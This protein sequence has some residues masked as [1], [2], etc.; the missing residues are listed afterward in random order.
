MCSTRELKERKSEREKPML[1]GNEKKSR[2]T[3]R[4]RNFPRWFHASKL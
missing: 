1:K 3:R 4:M 2:I